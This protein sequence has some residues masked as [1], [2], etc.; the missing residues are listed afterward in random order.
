MYYKF[1]HECM[2]VICSVI[3]I[4][5]TIASLVNVFVYDNYEKG[6]WFMLLA[7]LNQTIK[8]DFK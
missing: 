3:V 1:S 5:T 4:M 8:Q 6:F 2:H 7:I